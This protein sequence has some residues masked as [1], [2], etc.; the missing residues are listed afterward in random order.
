MTWTLENSKNNESRKVLWELVP[1][2]RGRCLDIGAGQ[3]KVFPHFVSVDSGHH[4]G[5]RD[6]DE[7]VKDAKDLSIFASCSVDLAYSSHLLEHFPYKDVPAVL[8]EWLRITKQNGHMILYIPDSE[9]YPKVGQPGANP[10]HKWDPTYE[11]VVQALEQS[12]YSWDIV[13]FQKRNKE[14]EYSLFFVVKRL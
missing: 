6:I 10:D 7:P 3:Y 11:L 9:E 5:L 8:D 12:R 4:W 2:M 13:D 1:Y 14:D